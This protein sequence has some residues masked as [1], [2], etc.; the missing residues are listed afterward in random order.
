MAK[1]VLYGNSADLFGTDVFKSILLAD[2]SLN[3]SVCR[4]CVCVFTPVAPGSGLLCVQSFLKQ[5]VMT[6]IHAADNEYE[7]ALKS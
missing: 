7:E 6:Y 3:E 4:K 1:N 5:R 2:R